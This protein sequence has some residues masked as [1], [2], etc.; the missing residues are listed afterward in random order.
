MGSGALSAPVNTVPLIVVTPPPGHVGICAQSGHG[1][2]HTPLPRAPQICPA[3]HAPQRSVPPHPSPMS[4]QY[5]PLPVGPVGLQTLASHAPES[6][7]A[8]HRLGVP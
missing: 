3:G 6:V 5:N 8:P 1:T 4:P 2:P 7:F